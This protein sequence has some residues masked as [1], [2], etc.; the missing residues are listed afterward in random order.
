MSAYIALGQEWGGVGI[1]GFLALC[2]SGHM[3]PCMGAPRAPRIFGF[4]VITA[5]SC[6]GSESFSATS[7]PV[8]TGSLTHAQGLPWVSPV[9]HTGALC[10]HEL[11]DTAQPARPQPSSS[12]G[13]SPARSDGSGP[14]PGAG[15]ASSALLLAHQTVN[16][17]GLGAFY[18]PEGLTGIAR[19]L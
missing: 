3:L 15:P 9:R 19:L 17:P 12:W 18:P 7:T 13:S 6:A 16:H 2:V 8:G 1:W 10:C 4:F 14:A 5:S 11:G